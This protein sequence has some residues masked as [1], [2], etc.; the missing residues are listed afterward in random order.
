M[1]GNS[2]GGLPIAW[3]INH[4]FPFYFFL[5][6]ATQSWRCGRLKASFLLRYMLYYCVK[7]ILYYPIHW[8]AYYVSTLREAQV[9]TVVTMNANTTEMFVQ[10]TTKLN[11][12]KCDNWHRWWE[13]ALRHIAMSLR[14]WRLSSLAPKREKSVFTQDS[15]TTTVYDRFLCTVLYM[16]Q[17]HWRSD[18]LVFFFCL[19]DNATS[20]RIP[21]GACCCVAPVDEWLLPSSTGPFLCGVGSDGGGY[22]P[23]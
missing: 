9:L 4:V 14:M 21:S 13:S 23:G 15:I 18:H 20:P 22:K 5:L 16:L 1:S 17:I 3:F 6:Q 8:T 10:A 7:P 12:Y 11:F 2:Q 19:T